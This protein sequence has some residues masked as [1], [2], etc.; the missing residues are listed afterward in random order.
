MEARES[1]RVLRNWQE[2][3]DSA[4]LYAAL[5]AAE[6]NPRLS[7]VFGKLAADERD[8]ASI[9]EQRLQAAG[10]PVPDYRPSARTRLVAALARRFGVNFVIPSITARELADRDR[11]SSQADAAAAGLA[12]AERRHAAVMRAVGTYGDLPDGGADAAAGGVHAFA[13]NL[14]AS[15]LGANDGLVSNFCL[16][17]GVAGAGARS[18]TILLT[19]AAG[20]V[21]GACSMALGEWLSVTSAREMASSQVDR[22]ATETAQDP[23][24]NGAQL[25][26]FYQAR[27]MSEH[28]ARRLAQRI[29]AGDPDALDRHARDALDVDAS[30][31]GNN[32]NSAAVH[33]FVLFACGAL[34]PLLPFLF[35]SAN[36]AIA[37]SIAA[38]LFALCGIGML[39]S[40]FTG[41]SAVFSGLRQVAIG[42]L[43]AAVTYGAGR[44]F[45][46]AI[47]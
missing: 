46:A 43:A 4:E 44:I 27:G 15:V 12:A 24:A 17:M 16:I 42:A 2:E 14:R 39:T 25:A 3:R 34:I 45:G 6:R 22:A 7:N 21:A 32:P 28:D 9:W 37:A 47:G 8:H 33:S 5:A 20:L 13:N 29:I 41:R 40:F 19:G 1:E 10:V 35:L 36:S 38:S 30:A 23:P 26:L 31:L 11:Y 18:A